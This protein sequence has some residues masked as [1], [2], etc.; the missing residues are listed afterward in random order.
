MVM[1]HKSLLLMFFLLSSCSYTQNSLTVNKKDIG[2]SNN[3]TFN[4]KLLEKIPTKSLKYIVLKNDFIL[5]TPDKLDSEKIKSEIKEMEMQRLNQEQE[6]E[7]IQW[8][9]SVIIWNEIARNLVIKYK[10]SPP[11]A[12]RVYAL[13]SVGQYDTLLSTYKNKFQYKRYL[14]SDSLIPSFPSEES[15]LAQVSADILSYL[16]PKEK[17]FLNVK[18]NYN[19]KA[20]FLSKKYLKSDITAGEEI[21]SLVSKHIIELASNDNS[22]H[23]K[24]SVIPIKGEGIWLNNTSDRLHGLLPSWGKVKM[25][26][27]RPVEILPVKAPPIYGSEDFNKNIEELITIN[28]NLTPEQSKTAFFWSDGFGTATPPGHWNLIASDLIK[29]NNL[30][31][32]EASYTM[33]LLNMAIMDAGICCWFIKYKYQ[34]LRPSEADKK[35]QPILSVPNFPSYPS[36][37]SSFSGA[38]ANILSFIFPEKQEYLQKLAEEASMSRLYGGIHYRFDAEEGLKNGKYIADVIINNVKTGS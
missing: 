29:S 19:K 7:I 28:K 18:L 9:N 23:S 32:L 30:N 34:I 27:N 6:S 21:G 11:E 31:N 22:N 10:T 38:A 20:V 37:H 3:I 5:N 16:Y 26:I 1:K 13:L 36:G 4:S 35:I 2:K 24:D 17:N 15:S 8:N 14:N 33:A 12:S 25:W